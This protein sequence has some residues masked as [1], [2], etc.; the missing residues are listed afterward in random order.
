LAKTRK[1][2]FLSRPRRFGKSSLVSTSEAI[3]TG[4]RELFEG[5][6]IHDRSNYDWTLNP[7][8]DLSL[9]STNTDSVNSVNRDLLETLKII[10]DKK[11]IDTNWQ[12]SVNF[13][14]F[15][16]SQAF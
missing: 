15:A 14:Q 7:I 16:F 11:G 1:L 4:R 9:N 12:I 8:I 13:F 6:W 10:A 5:L 3:L 2:C